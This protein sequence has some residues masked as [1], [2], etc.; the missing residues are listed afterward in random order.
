MCYGALVI[1]VLYVNNK[2]RGEQEY[3]RGNNRS[4]KHQ[5]KEQNQSH[6]ISPATSAKMA[7]VRAREEV[8]R[9]VMFHHLFR[10][11][12]ITKKGRGMHSRMQ[13]SSTQ[14]KVH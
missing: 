10:P 9:R 12:Q 1:L 13:W 2:K 11:F 4:L 5:T 7:T 8:T 3:Y 14:T 6:K